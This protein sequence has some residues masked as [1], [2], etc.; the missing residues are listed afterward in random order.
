MVGG[1]VPGAWAGPLWDPPSKEGGVW[2]KKKKKVKERI[3]LQPSHF[4]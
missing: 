3:G 2:L 1:P 4:I